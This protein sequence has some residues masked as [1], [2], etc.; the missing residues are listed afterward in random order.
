MQSGR[1]L[2]HELAELYRI[3]VADRPEVEPASGPMAHIVTLDG[4]SR[5]GGVLGAQALGD[6]QIDDVLAALI[7]DGG[8]RLAVDVI[9]TAAEQRKTLRR[10]VDHRRRDVDLAVE[11]RLDG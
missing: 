9:E 3:E 6:E 7:D 10:Q 11:P 4:P 8:H 5:H 2:L 1:Y